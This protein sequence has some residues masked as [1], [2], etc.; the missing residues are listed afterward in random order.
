MNLVATLAV[1]ATAREATFF[2]N[3]KKNDDFDEDD[4]DDDVRYD[5]QLG[6]CDRGPEGCDDRTVKCATV[7]R[8][9]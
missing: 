6:V 3:K 9:H 8:R 1:I 7:L 2:L 4:N 5:F